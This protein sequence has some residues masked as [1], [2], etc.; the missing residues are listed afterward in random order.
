M[1]EEKFLGNGVKFTLNADFEDEIP[2]ID[3]SFQKGEKEQH[4][5]QIAVNEKS[6][7]VITLFHDENN[8]RINAGIPPHLSGGGKRVRLFRN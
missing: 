7:C 5:A 6:G 2:V 8:S 3:L 4:V 1:K